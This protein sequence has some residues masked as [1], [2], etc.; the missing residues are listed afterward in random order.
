MESAFLPKCLGS[1][2]V[3]LL[4]LATASCVSNDCK[5]ILNQV[6]LLNCNCNEKLLP[7][8]GL[9]PRK[10][11]WV[12]RDTGSGSHFKFILSNFRIKLIF[13]FSFIAQFANKP[14]LTSVVSW[15][16][17]SG[18]CYVAGKNSAETANVNCTKLPVPDLGNQKLNQRC[19]LRFAEG[20]KAAKNETFC[21]LGLTNFLKAGKCDPPEV[22]EFGK[23]NYAECCLIC[24]KLRAD[25]KKNQT[26]FLPDELLPFP[27]KGVLRAN[28]KNCCS[29]SARNCKDG[30]FYNT[31]A[32]SCEGKK[33]KTDG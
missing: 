3:F 22:Y 15:K 13:L 29:P 12:F 10:I 23:E 14:S 9:N 19:I 30:T 16:Q 11:C 24:E 6:M 21:G 28:F 25:F 2:L 33:S 18:Y 7:N 5:L 17:N 27:A 8:R 4:L 31:Q 20:C 32:N 1:T 26:C